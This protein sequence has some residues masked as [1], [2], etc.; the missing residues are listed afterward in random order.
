MTGKIDPQLA[1]ELLARAD[2][3]GATARAGA[4]WPHVAGLLGM[5]ASSSLAIVAFAYV[6]T[7][8]IWLPMGL[9][10]VWFVVVASSTLSAITLAGAWVEASR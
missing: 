5:G 2:G 8:L 9:L 10:F 1:H 4:S 6:P 3:G 7:P